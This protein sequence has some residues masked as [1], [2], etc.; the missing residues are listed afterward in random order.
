MKKMILG[1]MAVGALAFTSCSSDD[2]N[3]SSVSLVGT[4]KLTAWNST[5][6][7]DINN[8]GTAN[9]NLLEEFN[10]YN[11]ETVVFSSNNTA[12]ANSTSYADITAEIT[13][14]TTDEFT[15]T[16]DCIDEIDSVPLTW[17]LAGNT[18]TFD[19]GSSDE[20]VGTLNGNTFSI[21]VPE[22]LV[23]YNDDFSEIVVNQDLTFVYT[24]Q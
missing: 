9:T 5:T 18:I 6:G 11:N 16:V 14:G 12:V 3:N 2:D 8:D 21:V 1:L 4:W 13:A 24:K 7:Y 22:G 17:S 15:Y 23:V 10:C 20:I 19:E